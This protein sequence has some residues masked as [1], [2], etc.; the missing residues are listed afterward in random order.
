M[1]SKKPPKPS[2]MEAN[3]TP[4]RKRS[5]SQALASSR[6]ALLNAQRGLLDAKG[7]D[8]IRQRAGLEAVIIYGRTVTWPLQVLRVPGEPL[9]EQKHGA[10]YAKRV[11]QRLAD[12]PVAKLFVKLRNELEKEGT[13]NAEQEGGNFV[14]PDSFLDVRAEAPPDAYDVRFR[15][16]GVVEYHT[17][18]GVITRPFRMMSIPKTIRFPDAPGDLARVDA[19]ELAERYL[20]TLATIVAEAEIAVGL[21]RFDDLH[22]EDDEG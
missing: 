10:W 19:R 3:K 12:D 13:L 11:K 5:P 9:D 4:P 20:Y 8:L 16:D 21:G 17:P 7:H 14:N 18:S 2:R 1:A 6:A 22:D 15:D